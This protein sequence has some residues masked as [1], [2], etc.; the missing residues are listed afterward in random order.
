MCS[1]C[2][3]FLEV[4]QYFDCELP[5]CQSKKGSVTFL[6][7]CEKNQL[8]RRNRL[9]LELRAKGNSSVDSHQRLNVGIQWKY[10]QY[11]YT[12]NFYRTVSCNVLQ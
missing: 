8:L 7:P 1:L 6:C 11:S 9:L 12:S 10:Q 2:T 5:R 4:G 3:E